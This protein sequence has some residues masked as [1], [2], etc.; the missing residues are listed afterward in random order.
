MFQFLKHV[1]CFSHAPLVLPSHSYSVKHCL[2][3]SGTGSVF[4]HAQTEMNER[5]QSK[6]IR[7]LRNQLTKL[8]LADFIIGF[9]GLYLI[10]E[11]EY[12]VYINS[13]IIK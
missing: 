7:A 2:L 10:Y 6:G 4:K 8:S 12:T 3:I 5:N 11:S 1:V 9:L 13:L